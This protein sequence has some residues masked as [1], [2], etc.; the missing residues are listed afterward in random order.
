MADANTNDTN[1]QE[2][3]V[4]ELLAENATL[5]QKVHD[6]NNESGRRRKQAKEFKALA[7]LEAHDPEVR[8][9][10]TEAL[11][12]TE[13]PKDRRKAALRLIDASGVEVT[14]DGAVTGI[15]EAIEQL[16][17]SYPW[18][19]EGS[20]QTQSQEEKGDQ[21]QATGSMH[22]AG[23]RKPRGRSDQDIARRYPSLGGRVPGT[24]RFG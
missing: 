4:K 24:R 1:D 6:L 3:S 16:Q 19:F 11:L 13:L 17:E 7:G 10:V 21:T 2:P 22:N 23:R 15:D 14:E 9:L 12:D 8:V 5:R 20:A 18:L